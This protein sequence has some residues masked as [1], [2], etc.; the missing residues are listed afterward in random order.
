MTDEFKNAIEGLKAAREEAFNRVANWN[1]QELNFKPSPESWNV[2]QIFQHILSSETGTFG[3]ILKKTSSGW[4]GLDRVG[5]E[6]KANGEKLVNRLSSTEKFAAPAVLPAPQGEESLDEVKARWNELRDKMIPFFEN[7]DEAFYDRLVFKQP[8]A[9]MISPIAAIQFLTKHI[10]HHFMQL[11][12][13]K[14][15]MK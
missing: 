14:S 5:E 8:A 15:A 9:G 11:D 4:E 6:E 7:M 2:I 13:L 12:E 1:E 3:Y 10:E